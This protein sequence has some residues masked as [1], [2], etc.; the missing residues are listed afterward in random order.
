MK[1]TVRK[2]SIIVFMTMLLVLMT[3]CAKQVPS[4]LAVGTTMPLN[5]ALASNSDTS[6][7]REKILQEINE[8]LMNM[9][10]KDLLNFNSKFLNNGQ[11]KAQKSTELDQKTE[12]EAQSKNLQELVN[13]DGVTL[14]IHDTD[15]VTISSI[16]AGKT[17]TTTT[18]ASIQLN[19][20]SGNPPESEKTEEQITPATTSMG[21]DNAEIKVYSRD[22]GSS[23]TITTTTESAT[24]Q[25]SEVPIGLGSGSVISYGTLMI[26]VGVVAA[27][28]LVLSGVL[29]NKKKKKS[30]LADGAEEEIKDEE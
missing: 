29:L 24:M 5:K 4:E 30:A 12:A 1:R 14:H 13:K 15:N 26:I 28:V 19:S 3:S 10:D 8:S 17:Y 6:I 25:L 27:V 18:D 9:D 20:S 23:L 16:Y 22:N 21:N 7:D 11:R 2:I